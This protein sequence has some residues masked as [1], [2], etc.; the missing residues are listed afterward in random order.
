VNAI[1]AAA[2]AELL[3]LGTATL[4]E[5]SGIDCLL[6][7]YLRPAWAGAAMVGRALPIQAPLG[8][9]LPLHRALEH[10]RA[11]DV[12]VVDARGGEFGYWGEVL[13]VAALAKGVVGLVIDG[14]VRDVDRLAAL[15]FSVFSASVALRTTIKKSGGTIGEPLQV[16]GVLVHRDDV[17][18]ADA[19]GVIA[20]PGGQLDAA[21]AGATR[22][23]DA[24]RAYLDRIRAGELTMDIYGL[25]V[26]LEAADA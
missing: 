9:N 6:P 10:V 13:T 20:I 15:N 4:Y 8:D 17:I 26:H 7:A 22:R 24:E 2:A 21:V 14:G 5:G 3:A 18:V 23:A 12:M 1:P 11:G 16:G 19:D 25:R